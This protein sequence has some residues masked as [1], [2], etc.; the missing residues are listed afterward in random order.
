MLIVDHNYTLEKLTLQSPII[1]KLRIIYE[2][3]VT[4]SVTS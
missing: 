2:A 1:T 4:Y 3:G